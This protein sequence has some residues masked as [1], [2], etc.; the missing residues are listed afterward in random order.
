[1][2]DTDT[3]AARLQAALDRI[4]AQ[5]RS[6]D[7]SNELKAQLAARLDKLIAQVR[8]ALDVQPLDA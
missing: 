6:P 8:E 7:P 3:P 2:P 4:A 5:A 1:M